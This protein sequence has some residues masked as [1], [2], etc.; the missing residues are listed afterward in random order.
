MTYQVPIWVSALIYFTLE[1]LLSLRAQTSLIPTTHL[2]TGIA[3]P[4][5]TILSRVKMAASSLP[6]RSFLP[7]CLG[8]RPHWVWETNHVGLAFLYSDMTYTMC[9]ID[10]SSCMWPLRAGGK[11]PT[12]SSLHWTQRNAEMVTARAPLLSFICLDYEPG[13][14]QDEEVSSCVTSCTHQHSQENARQMHFPSIRDVRS[15]H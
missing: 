11:S 12:D 10:K 6:W 2:L 15:G 1:P 4:E 8:M 3:A 9:T 5:F 13:E 14:D 7:D